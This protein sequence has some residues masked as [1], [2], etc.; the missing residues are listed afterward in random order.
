MAPSKRDPIGGRAAPLCSFGLVARGAAF[1]IVGGLIIA[2]AVQFDPD[3]AQGLDGALDT[4]HRQP[5]G[6]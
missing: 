5:Y 1:F 2:A 4:L 6:P 3:K